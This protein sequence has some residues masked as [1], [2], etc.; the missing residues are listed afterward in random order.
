[1]PITVSASHTRPTIRTHTQQPLPGVPDLEVLIGELVTVD[2][3][4]ASTCPREHGSQP[5][6]NKLTITPGE[7]TTLN[8]EVLDHAVESRP[9]ISEAFL[10]GCQSPF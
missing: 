1:M 7:V 9:F 6:P 4:S 3:L 8:H 5:T 10:A 2:R